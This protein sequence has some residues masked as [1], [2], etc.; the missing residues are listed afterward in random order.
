MIKKKKTNKKQTK[1]HVNQRK[2]I[3][4]SFPTKQNNVMHSTKAMISK[5]M[6]LQYPSTSC[7]KYS[8][9]YCTCTI[10]SRHESKQIKPATN[11]KITFRITMVR[12]VNAV[13]TVFY[14]SQL[15]LFKDK[16]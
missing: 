5:S 10:P 16:D 11:S 14:F 13:F 3:D 7:N 4:L 6:Q 8:P 2:N 15:N 1:K 12:L 9:E